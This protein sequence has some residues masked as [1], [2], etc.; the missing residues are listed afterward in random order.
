MTA[1]VSRDRPDPAKP[2]QPCLMLKSP[3]MADAIPKN[4]SNPSVPYRVGRC[5]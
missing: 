4:W 2:D 5:R 3:V 1:S